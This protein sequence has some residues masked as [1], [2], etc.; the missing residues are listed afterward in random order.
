MEQ[1]EREARELEAEAD[2]MEAETRELDDEIGAV[3]S[4]WESKKQDQSVPG[5][6]PAEGEEPETDD[7]GPT[8]DQPGP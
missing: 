4:D 3:R 6:V 7:P 1:H 8:K 5:A 2:R